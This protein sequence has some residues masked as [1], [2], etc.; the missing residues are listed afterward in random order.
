MAEMRKVIL[1]EVSTLEITM[2]KIYDV[3]VTVHKAVV[4]LYGFQQR[5][6]KIAQTLKDIHASIAHVHDWKMRYK[7][8]PL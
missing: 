5:C 1:D 3:F 2:K 7:E 4:H 8:A 6:M